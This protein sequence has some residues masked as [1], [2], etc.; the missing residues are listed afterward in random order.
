M[1]SAG[2]GHRD[3]PPPVSRLPLH[4][5]LWQQGAGSRR[6][7]VQ[8]KRFRLFLAAAGNSHISLRS[9]THTYAQ[10]SSGVSH[11]GGIWGSARHLP[12]RG[13][14]SW[15]S[16]VCLKP[17]SRVFGDVTNTNSNT[18][19]LALARICCFS[20]SREFIVRAHAFAE[21]NTRGV[22]PSV[23]R[24]RRTRFRAPAFST[25]SICWG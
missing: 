25:R 16:C 14:T 4:A 10:V 9:A 2:F 6:F 15:R 21:K 18:L 1:C 7:I 24:C 23:S 22:L 20:C 3:A 19:V 5:E 13:S 17:S 12:P 8:D 11:L